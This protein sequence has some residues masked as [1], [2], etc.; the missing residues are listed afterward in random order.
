MK[1]LLVAFILTSVS[2]FAEIKT[3]VYAPWELNHAEQKKKIEE[4]NGL[5]RDGWR[6]VQ[7]TYHFRVVI[8]T[9]EKE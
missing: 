7:L 4:I 2:V 9:L 8:Y 5:I 3:I 1:K 6:I